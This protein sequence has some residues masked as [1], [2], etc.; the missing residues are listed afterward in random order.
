MKMNAWVIQGFSFIASRSPQ[1][2]L[3]FPADAWFLRNKA[4]VPGKTTQKTPCIIYKKE[5]FNNKGDK[6]YR[7]WFSLCLIKHSLINPYPS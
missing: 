6:M 1:F 3:D 2:S 7:W 5:D 4:A